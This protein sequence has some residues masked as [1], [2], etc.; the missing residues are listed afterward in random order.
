[1][2]LSKALPSAII[3]IL[4]AT[5]ATANDRRSESRHRDV[6][7]STQSE[8]EARTINY[9]THTLPQSCL[10]TSWASSSTSTEDAKKTT[11]AT[12]ANAS[13]T[14]SESTRTT[15]EPTSTTDEATASETSSEAEAEETPFMAFEDWKEMMLRKA[16]Q[17][18]QEMRSRK[19]R[20]ASAEDRIPP[21]GGYADLGEEDEIS[22]KFNDY[23]DGEDNRRNTGTAADTG[24]D[25]DAG[26]A[27]AYDENRPWVHRSQDAGKTCKER[28]SYS[29]FDAG[30]TVLKTGPSTKNPKAI[31]VE[32]K[33][34]YMLLECRKEKFVIVELSED[35]LIDTIVLANFE[36]FSSMI[37]HFRVSVSDRYP[38][39][40]DKWKE[41]GVFE[42]RNSRD[43]QPFLVE[44]PQIWAKYLRI[45]FLTH[46]GN[47]YYCP[48]S[49][50]RVHGSRM[51]DSWKDS[52]TGREDEEI[53][54]EL[55][56]ENPDGAA[57]DTLHDELLEPEVEDREK[58]VVPELEQNFSPKSRF[59]PLAHNFPILPQICTAA[60]APK[61]NRSSS[62]PTNSV[63]KESKE[64]ST[65][66]S[67]ATEKRDA[68]S[69][70]PSGKPRGETPDNKK[71][72]SA[73]VTPPPEKN[74]KSDGDSSSRISSNSTRSPGS[75]PPSGGTV[76]NTTTSSSSSS[77]GQS[78]SSSNMSKNRPSSTASASG[79]SPTVQQSFFNAITK[80]LQQVE[81]NLT[82]SL[83]Y[84]E[85]QSR[86]MQ[87]AEQK[88]ANK[89]TQF[90]ENLNQTVLNEL[91][92]IR[93]Q[94]DQIW[95]STVIALE[96]QREH[97]ERDIVA[98][99][100]RLNLLADE[101]VFQKRMAIVQAILLLS[102][103]FLVIFSRGVPIPYLQPFLDQNTSPYAPPA[104]LLR[105]DFAAHQPR[106]NG[107]VTRYPRATGNGS[108][109]SPHAA[110]EVLNGWQS[111]NQT[112][113][114]LKDADGGGQ[115]R[116]SPPLTPILA[117]L[118]P[119]EDAVSSGLDVNNASVRLQYTHSRKPLPALP[120]HPVSTE[121][122]EA[123][124]DS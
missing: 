15:A 121:E 78:Q 19:T 101:V 114:P 105:G 99:S 98:L 61:P 76:A 75:A 70:S 53:A 122:D 65:I 48:V 93:E 10:T 81:A 16:G 86:H 88:Q 83:T 39:K 57:N 118:G 14:K 100:T 26:N 80:R 72:P 62:H 34:S 104:T 54:E 59:P 60:D 40:A 102:C 29:S 119:E 49:L 51:F 109:L 24:D 77:R 97:T 90:L 44:N 120:E 36:F 103:L 68:R 117:G 1:M 6:G 5:T 28:F 20:E 3:A 73:P 79:S 112:L 42:A 55:V 27:L 63:S 84:I 106:L 74:T 91:R 92:S 95:Q 94:T 38:V 124:I 111:P 58:L 23:L 43:L 50:L 32:N 9:I 115:E 4:S 66:A 85:E 22:L 30:A 35:I 33:D 56:P 87:R 123:I 96:T 2:K 67:Q 46:Y 107:D 82:L 108:T 18:P 116:L 89:V 21:E 17:D 7:T 110:D 69:E 13:V 47:E 71:E 113:P 31:L 11:T 25:N 8:C 64:K 41:V 45:E 52:E 12:D 37:R